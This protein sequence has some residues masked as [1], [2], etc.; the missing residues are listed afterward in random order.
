[1]FLMA[2]YQT[3]RTFDSRL[4]A[5]KLQAFLT[6]HEIPTIFEEG[7]PIFNKVL[8][9]QIEELH[10]IIKIPVERFKAAE[11]ALEAAVDLETMPVEPD[12]Y[13]VSFSDEELID[14][15]RKKDEWGK[16]DY[17]L[18]KQLLKERGI[19]LDD[20]AIRK[21]ERERM[22]ALS[23]PEKPAFYIILVGYVAA[24]MASG[25]GVV[26]GL[27]LLTAYKKL[28]DGQYISRFDRLTR[29]HAGTMITLGVLI[30]ASYYI[31]CIMYGGVFYSFNIWS[32]F[33]RHTVGAL[34]V[35]QTSLI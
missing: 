18:A 10:Y 34:P 4:E 24:V 12:Y 3:F 27:Y 14:V 16:F 2:S 9:G 17:V 19:V 6:R 21:M 8:A 23:K 33:L 15:V 7:V 25:I 30:I 29:R 31:Y 1:M 32:V 26:L 13:L 20:V 5:V 28:P 35:S 11:A 22:R